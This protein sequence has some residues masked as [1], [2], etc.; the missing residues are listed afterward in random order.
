MIDVVRAMPKGRVT[1]S[2]THDSMPGTPPDGVTVKVMVEVKPEEAMIEV[3]MTD[4]IDSMP[5][6]LNLSEGCALSGPMVAIFNS[7]DHTVPK[8]AGSFRRIT[9]KLRDG[10]A[11]GRP[12]HPTSCS[13]AT[14]NL[15]D[16]VANPTQCAL[17]EMGDGMGMAETGRGVAAVDRRAVGRP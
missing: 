17:A 16:R 7:I 4:N 12:R 13:V 1:R 6:G 9:V 11:V 3:D 14:T 10:C 2:S 5:N 8:N 15:A